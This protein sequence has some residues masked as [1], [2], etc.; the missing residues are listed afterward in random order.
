MHFN[1][2]SGKSV[3]KGHLE[4]VLALDGFA[5]SIQSFV[6]TSCGLQTTWSRDELP[7]RCFPTMQIITYALTGLALHWH[8]LNMCIQTLVALDCLLCTGKLL[9]STAANS[10]INNQ[11]TIAALMRLLNEQPGDC[12]IERAPQ[13]F[14]R[15]LQQLI[16]GLSL[17][18]SEA[19]LYKQRG[20]TSLS[21]ATDSFGCCCA[22]GLGN[23]RTSK[24]YFTS[25]QTSQQHPF[26]R[27]NFF[28]RPSEL[29]A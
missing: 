29:E 26:R 12:I 10:M 18:A 20:A 17:L 3:S 21:Q 1:D 2:A 5:H 6:D 22:Q 7:T 19:L 28:F 8:G 13:A 24:F 15:T 16:G 23:Q 4:D 9:Q 11:L 25:L 27:Q 14:R